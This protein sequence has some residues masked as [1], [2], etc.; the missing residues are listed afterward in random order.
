[1]PKVGS[2]HYAYTPKG[3]AAA[4]SQAQKTGQKVTNT[5]K[6]KRR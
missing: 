2:T 6:A 5:K 3:R 1:M 4:K